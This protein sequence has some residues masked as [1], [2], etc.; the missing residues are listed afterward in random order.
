MRVDVYRA[1]WQV[2]GSE[3]RS[4]LECTQHVRSLTSLARALRA[5]HLASG[6]STPDMVQQQ[7]RPSHPRRVPPTR[8]PSPPISHRNDIGALPLLQ[9]E[10]CQACQMMGWKRPTKIQQEAIP[11]AIQG[12][13]IIG[14][15][16]TG[17]GK[18][19]A[20]ALPIVQRL[21]ER[22]P[23]LA[24]LLCCATILCPVGAC[25]RG[26]RCSCRFG[27]S[28]VGGD[29]AP[30][31]LGWL[32][33][34]ATCSGAR[35]SGAELGTSA[36][37][38]MLCRSVVPIPCC[39]GSGILSLIGCGLPPDASRTLSPSLSLRGLRASFCAPRFYATGRL[40]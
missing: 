26:R 21:L 37:C 20:F 39:W 29:T 22:P 38:A 10:L 32:W 24:R 33:W 31:A 34:L 18:T 8:V 7:G 35:R 28:V 27:C 11:W 1:W 4:G 36:L 25:D 5:A 6:N 19:G 14:L 30:P 23:R 9:Q 16:E 17:S 3:P 13:D 2:F 40:P 12:R 15:A